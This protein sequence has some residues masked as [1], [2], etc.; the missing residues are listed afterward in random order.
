MTPLAALGETQYVRDK[1]GNTIQ[2]LVTHGD[3]TDV[4]DV[5]GNT[6]GYFRNG[7]FYDVNGNLK[8][9]VGR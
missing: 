3:R 1:N 9:R 5:N 4:R 2:Q 6:Q 8:Y 7:G